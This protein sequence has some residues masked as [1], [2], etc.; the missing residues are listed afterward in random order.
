MNTSDSPQSE[1]PLT[2][3]PA[4]TAP[5]LPLN[6]VP[7]DP[8]DSVAR[9][10]SPTDLAQFAELLAGMV[11]AKLPLPQA[12]RLLGADTSNRRLRE[13]LASLER[14]VAA[15]V[16]LP[17]AMQRQNG[18]FPPLF[19]KLVA[20]G[21]AANDLHATLIELVRE[22]RSQ[23]RFR[24]AMW[25]QLIGPIATSVM[26]VVVLGVVIVMNLPFAMTRPYYQI[27]HSLRIDAP[28]PTRMLVWVSEA[29][30][31][32]EL[33][34]LVSVIL[35]GIAVLIV[36]LLRQPATR[37]VAQDWFL[38]LPLIG[39]YLRTI[40]LARFCR[41]LSVLLKSKLPLDTALGLV[42]D[43]FTYLPVRGSVQR[44][45]A[46]ANDGQSLVAA[47]KTQTFFPPTFVQFVEGAALHGNLDQSLSNLA[48]SYE[49]R[50]TLEAARLRMLVYILSMLALGCLVI[51]LILAFFLPMFHFHDALRKK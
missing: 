45:A 35:C 25:T 46:K 41:L 17:E 32:T 27:Y 2:D 51:W 42:A 10:L 28:F 5:V 14:D 1:A 33:L 23:A 19:T 24:E 38:G 34:A 40:F 4:T 9:P 30:R 20:S 43:S 16:P 7:Q 6:A 8:S 48:E 36:A 18:R 29:L 3:V 12:L 50:A 49:Q 47:L 37:E 44:V 15:G 11:K 39:S 31:D 13:T 22:Y 21:C 26:F